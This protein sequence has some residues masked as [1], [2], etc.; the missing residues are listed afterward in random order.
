M[1]EVNF[2]RSMRNRVLQEL[3]MAAP[4][5]ATLRVKLHRWRGVK[6]G[7]QVWIGH[8]AM[9]ENAY[10]HLVEIGNNVSIGIRSTLIAHFRETQG[11]WIEDDVF[12]GPCCC[13]LPAVRIGKGSVVT[14][15]SVVTTSVPPMTVVQGNPARVVA[16][17]AAPLLIDTSMASFLRGLTPAR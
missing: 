11:I 15:G 1:A 12:I 3:A 6:I 2:F 17:C 14:A 16:R 4:G 13:I 5:A 10:P 7:R 8:Q 9:I